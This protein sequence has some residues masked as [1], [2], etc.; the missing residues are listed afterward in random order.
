MN[1]SINMSIKK[2]VRAVL[3][4]MI[5]VLFCSCDL[6]M[7]DWKSYLDYW[8]EAVLMGRVEV[9]GATF[10][11]NDAG[12]QTLP[13]DATAKI[14]GYVINPQG[15]ALVESSIEIDDPALDGSAT[16]NVADPTLISVLL[17]N[18]T[19]AE[20][21]TFT[22]NF[23]P[24]RADTGIASTETM[25]VT[26]QYNTPPAAPLRMNS[27]GNGGFEVVQ[28]GSTWNADS[29]GNLYWKWP[30]TTTSDT[31]PN[32]V[33]WFSIDGTR[34][35][36]STCEDPNTSGIYRWKTGN[37][38][39]KLAAV[40]SEGI[41]G[42]SITSGV[43]V[44]AGEVI[45]YQ[46]TF[47]K[48]GGREGSDSSSA[49]YGGTPSKI[50]PPSRTGYTFEGYYTAQNGGGTQYY[51]K[52][53][54]GVKSWAEFSD[55]ILYAKWRVNSY[56]ITFD[57]NGGSGGTPSISVVYDGNPSQINPPSRTGYIFGGY[58]TAQNGGGTQYYDGTGAGVASW[59]ESSD[60][61]LYAYWS[62]VK[63]ISV[64]KHPT[65][66]LY[67]EGETFDA[68]GLQVTATSENNQTQVLTDN[69]YTV[70]HTT[71]ARGAKQ[72]ITVTYKHDSS[73]TAT[74][75]VNVGAKFHETPTK[76]PAGT[77]G[78][79]GTNATYVEF[80]I[81][82]Q[83]SKAGDVSIDKNSSKTV[84]N[85]T[86]YLGSDGYWYYEEG[87]SKEWFKVEPIKW[88]VLTTNY[89]SNYLLLAENMLTSKIEYYGFSQAR[90]INGQTIQSNNY[91]Y[92]TARVWLNGIY[93]SG[94]RSTN[95]YSNKGFLQTAFTSDAQ[96]KIVVTAVDNGE[97]RTS[98]VGKN[99]G[100]NPYICENTNDKIFLLSR[101]EATSY[102]FGVWNYEDPA[103]VRMPTDYVY[104]E[105]GRDADTWWEGWYLR[106]PN[107][108]YTS[109]CY[110]IRDGSAYYSGS[111]LNRNKTIGIVPALCVSAN[112][113]K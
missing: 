80:G 96:S 57:Q 41:S 2:I 112:N 86:Y 53:G 5:M 101:N 89:N 10:Q 99:F 95:D 8:S 84:G 25:S 68:A 67:L 105:A 30:Y 40:D 54:A 13:L 28:A 58:Y 76:L 17:Q 107:H 6:W 69:D 88:R 60:T 93:E 47:N 14:S 48:N 109:D 26:L 45:V 104:V 78:T 12:V 65:K 7:N 111:V 9:S 97:F 19:V 22:V 103:R 43:T 31:E 90:T 37:K 113:I 50:E 56:T 55:A 98:P 35:D 23:T 3:V 24:E 74:F 52:T 38:S 61:T 106:S 77:D 62:G 46:I 82:P 21:T 34:Y 36:V 64:T 71:L 1:G 79:G 100:T 16:K 102:G 73:I 44:P 51:D 75:I 32:D 27:D 59:E 70:S 91:R 11:T 15:H 49:V 20:H 33:K 87:K 66:R 72:T 110:I 29:D 81:W 63:S 94:D 83:T 92:S 18:V 42:S 4:A 85:H 39:V 108:Q